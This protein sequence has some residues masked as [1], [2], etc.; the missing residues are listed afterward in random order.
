MRWALGLFGLLLGCNTVA[1]GHQFETQ[2][3]EALTAKGIAIR[4][5]HCPAH[6]PLNSAT[7][8]PCNAEMADGGTPVITVSIDEDGAVSWSY[9]PGTDAV[10]AT[11]LQ[12][13]VQQLMASHQ[14]TVLSVACPKGTPVG[15]GKVQC[16]TTLPSKDVFDVDVEVTADATLRY[17]VDFSEVMDPDKMAVAIKTD[18][19]KQLGGSTL[20]N[21]GLLRR[22]DAAHH[23]TC[24]AV[25]GDQRGSIVVS[26]DAD[27]T[28]SWKVAE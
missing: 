26:R 3:V 18:L 7:S 16:K 25:R 23:W 1:D 15:G 24:S 21:C 12:Q 17:K 4:A 14:L 22:A 9:V 5:L 19:H 27:G 11:D 13:Q 20:V 2:V 6:I 8:F 10:T 28:F